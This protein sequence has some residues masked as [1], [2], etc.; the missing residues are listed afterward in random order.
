MILIYERGITSTQ[1]WCFNQSELINLI[2][3]EVVSN[4]I[5]DFCPYYGK[6]ILVSFPIRNLETLQTLLFP[7]TKNVQFCSGCHNQSKKKITFIVLTLPNKSN[8]KPKH[9]QK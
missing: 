5:S 8:L 4:P 2:W 1:M 3:S 9:L 7:S 6:L